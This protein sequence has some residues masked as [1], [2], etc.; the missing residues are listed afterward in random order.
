MNLILENYTKLTRWRSRV[1]ALGGLRHE[2][3]QKLR[4]HHKIVGVT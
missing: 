4:V 1:H 2:Q 3:E